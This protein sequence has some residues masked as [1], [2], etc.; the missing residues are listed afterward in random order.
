[1]NNKRRHGF[2]L[3][4]L[5]VVI[6]IIAL[7]L[8]VLLP[9]LTK[10]KSQSKRIV[11]MSNVR[12]QVI[13]LRM[14][15]QENEG[16]YPIRSAFV[17][18]LSPDNQEPQNEAQAIALLTGLG[19]LYPAYI[20]DPHMFYCPAD[21][22]V[23]Y[24]G[25]YSWGPNFPI[26]TTGGAN[27]INSDYIYLYNGSYTEPQKSDDFVRQILTSDFYPLG[28]GENTHKIGYSLGYYDGSAHWYHDKSMTVIKETSGFGSNSPI[29]AQWWETFS[30]FC[31]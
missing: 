11:C 15:S 2:T 23:K 13:G 30:R 3:I 14:Y 6:A 5:L 25:Q 27:G 1:M 20:S 9:A 31:N 22:V 17:Y 26:H 7:L 12:Q 19:K 29:C 16:Y 21:T 10:V 4:E 8:S 24:D 28:Y 18:S